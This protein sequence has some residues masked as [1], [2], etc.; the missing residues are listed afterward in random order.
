MEENLDE[1]YKSKLHWQPFDILQLNERIETLLL[2]LVANIYGSC[3]S[4][5][6][7]TK[8]SCSLV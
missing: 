5:Y 8:Q 4:T 6:I 2:V 7:A 3:E 1:F